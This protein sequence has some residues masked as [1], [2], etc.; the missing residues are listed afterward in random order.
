MP[1]G[2]VPPFVRSALVTPAVAVQDG[3]P[4]SQPHDVGRTDS[5]FESDNGRKR[6]AGVRR[7]NRDRSAWR[8][9]SRWQTSLSTR[10]CIVEQM[11]F[12]ARSVAVQ[13][14]TRSFPIGYGVLLPD[15][16]SQVTVGFSVFGPSVGDGCRVVWKPTARRIGLNGQWAVQRRGS[17]RRQLRCHKVGRSAR[18]AQP[19]TSKPLLDPAIPLVFTAC[20]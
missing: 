2:N 1:I 9:Q 3:C 13:V 16:M 14:T 15:G 6:F 18:L 10:T 17:R 7:R 5:G 8:C 19:M 11:N 4:G 20:E 12:P